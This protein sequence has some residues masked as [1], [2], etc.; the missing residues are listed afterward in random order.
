MGRARQPNHTTLLNRLRRA[1]QSGLVVCPIGDGSLLELLRQS[2]IETRMATARVMD[3]LS[4]GV[5]IQNAQ[6]R[7]TTEVL[8]FIRIATVP[9]TTMIPPVE[10]VWLKAAYGLGIA[11][12]QAAGVSDDE[13][14]ALAKMFVDLMWSLTLEELMTDTPELPDSIHQGFRETATELTVASRKY[15]TEIRD[16]HSLYIDEVYGFLDAYSDDIQHALLRLYELRTGN[17]QKPTVE[18]LHDSKRLFVNAFTNLIRLG[19]AGT[20]LPRVQIEAGIHAIIRWHR[21]RPFSA[22]DFVDINHATAALPY[23][24][25]FLSETFLGTALTRPPLNLARRFGAQVVWDADSAVRAIEE[26]LARQ[27]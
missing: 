21:T 3:E 4:L 20:A 13:Q 2:D 22:Q 24:H 12:P 5:A 1:V 17:R 10:S 8:D 7:L 16:W 25:L 6:D 19:K 23:C 27:R 11:Y 9:S 14:L 26:V 15:S 18:E